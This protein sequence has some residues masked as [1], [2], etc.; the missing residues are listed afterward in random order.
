MQFHCLSQKRKKEIQNFNHLQSTIICY[1]ADGPGACGVSNRA[2]ADLTPLLEAILP[3]LPFLVL[4]DF[5]SSTPISCP[6]LNLTSF[7]RI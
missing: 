7:F 6:F 5:V 3:A 2:M 4:I 1:L